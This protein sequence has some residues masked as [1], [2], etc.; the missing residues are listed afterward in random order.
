MTSCDLLPIDQEYTGS[1]NKNS[2]NVDNH[3][4]TF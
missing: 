1:M 3:D 4:Q 2:S